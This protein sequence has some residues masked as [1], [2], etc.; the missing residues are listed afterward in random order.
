MKS[1]SIVALLIG[2]ALVSSFLIPAGGAKLETEKLNSYK[3]LI[4]QKPDFGD[5]KI[6]PELLDIMKKKGDE[7]KDII[8][9]LKKGINKQRVTNFLTEGKKARALDRKI[10]FHKL[11]NSIS[12][13]VKV[14]DIGDLA[15]LDDIERIYDDFKVTVSL[16]QSV[17]LI[18]AKSLWSRYDGS[19]I[20]V[21]VIDT[22]IDSTHPDLAGKVVDEVSFV[23]DESPMDGYGHGTHVA[24]IIAGS[25]AASDGK[26]KGVAPG[27]S[28]INV[29]VLDEYGSGS[30][31]TVM[32]GIEYAVD[33]GVN[34]ISMSIGA[35]LW[36]ADGSDP[37]S[38]TANAAVDAG[39]V[40]VVAAGNNGEP[41]TVSSPGVAE[42]VITVGASTKKDLIAG[43][44]S[45]GP[46][47]D[48]R[49]KPDV[50]APGGDMDIFLNPAD[51]GIVSARADGSLLD[52]N[53]PDYRVDKYYL[54]LSGTSMATPHVSGLAALLLQAK[55]K[56]TPDQVKQRLM[57]TG[58][59][60]GYSPIAQG[61]GRIDA[62]AALD[63]TIV[64]SPF[65][66]SYVGS[67]GTGRKET[68][69]IT[70]EGRKKITL[71]LSYTGD[72]IIRFSNNK[73]TLNPGETQN[74]VT[75]I[76][77]PAGLSPGQH[78]GNILVYNG[79]TLA[80]RVPIL[81]DTPMTFVKDKSEISDSIK[82]KS[83]G[84][85]AVYYY[86]DVPEGLPGISSTLK[87]MN[88][89][90]FVDIYLLNPK[91]ELVDYD[92]SNPE[93][94]YT[95]VSANNP[96]SGRWVILLYSMS[97]DS[98]IKEIPVSLTTYF[99]SLKLTPT[100][101][102]PESIISSGS[103]IAQD[104]T[105]TNVGTEGKYVMVNSY[106]SVPNENA[107]GSFSGAVSN[108]DFNSTTMEHWFD[109]PEE[110]S[111][112]VFTLT[113]LNN[114]AIIFAD[115]IDPNGMYVTSVAAGSWQP[116][117]V[118]VK[119]KDPIAGTWKAIVM[120]GFAMDNITEYYRGDY[121]VFFK[122][123]TWIKTV[124]SSLFV[125]GSARKDFSSTM[126][127]PE[128]ANGYYT[129]EISLSENG[130]KLKIPI[131]INV[132]NSVSYPGDFRGEIKNKEW[133]YYNTEINSSQ[134]NV[135]ITWTNANDLDLFLMDPNGLTEASSTQTDSK[136]E[137]VSIKN[138]E[139]GI[140]TIGVFGYNV[141]GLEEFA[142]TVS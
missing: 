113:A 44:S 80:A 110:S 26:Y 115:L 25:G 8:V 46:T 70:N 126:T 18:G 103:S 65:S 120:M 37:I 122:D 66:L 100:S 74:I 127:V 107:S 52:K 51:S 109:I 76:G 29:K 47:W 2:M 4:N 3:N 54:A 49:F 10:T 31:S 13:R 101:W 95:S 43:Y 45:Q 88:I 96:E 28:L 27:A 92:Y 78:S 106:M 55:P 87:T 60:L 81:Q 24:G 57:N 112:Y 132:G 11:S 119:I 30:A 104:F 33:K 32:S 58:I 118:S 84:R 64:V 23:K 1:K 69:K 129:G 17:P 6:Q 125:S 22:G 59:D 79:N 48:H 75:T 9:V 38:I 116:A 53:L 121:N 21:A 86:V 77:F 108:F 140:W 63:T 142:G 35:S 131:S 20:K 89:S 19:G 128:D 82:I 12:T 94:I 85:G 50:V 15:K 36:S 123:N 71:S 14:R 111:Q 134:L 141:T 42:K 139:A 91:G 83:S 130:E 68:L 137:S 98:F 105:I 34:I 138:P 39:V 7:E 62:V 117:S 56:L 136:E 16:D 40:V 102:S 97:F 99:N 114:S 61:A 67:P 73:V 93:K 124:P 5:Q 135:S 90:A 41:F 72:M 133:K